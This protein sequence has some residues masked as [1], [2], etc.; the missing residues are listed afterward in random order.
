MEFTNALIN[1]TSPYLLQHAHNPVN[2]LPWSE[3]VFEKAKKENKLVLLSIG[4]SACHWCH[5]MEHESFEDPKVAEIMNTYFINVKIDR[6]ERPDVDMLYMTAVQLMNGQGG[7]PLNC[8]TLPDGR[9]VYGG[10][11]FP[12]QQWVN[13]LHN[14]GELFGNDK[15]KVEQYAQELTQ[16]I[17]QAEL[18]NTKSA[19]GVEL[20]PSVLE[21]C[22]FNWTKR[23]DREYGG[24]NRAPKFPLP[25]NYSFLLKYAYLKNDKGLLDY[26]EL[27]LQKMACGGIYDQLGGGFARYS[28]DIYW[29]VPHFEKML[30]DNAQLVTLYCE[31]YRVSKNPLYKEVVIETLKFVE[32]EFLSPDGGFYSALDADSEGI[33]GKYYVWQEEELKDLLGKHYEVFADYF[34]VN[35]TGYWEDEN[36]ILM[37]TEDIS[38]LLVKHDLKEAELQTIIDESKIILKE[39]RDK[40]IKPGLDDK[41]LTSWNALMCKGYCEAYLTFKDKQYKTI[42][43]RNAEFISEKLIKSD[44]SL[45][46]SYKGGGKIQGFLDDY[47]F[48]IDA[49]LSVYLITQDER[50]IEKADKLCEY[51]FFNFY[52][53]ETGLFYY[54]DLKNEKLVVR[55]TE[56]S[57]NVIPSSNS[58]MAINLFRLSKLTGKENYQKTS[59]EMLRRFS[60][61]IM[62]YGA[63]YSNW[64]SLYI[65]LLEDH[66]EVCIVGKAVEEK[67]LS[68][69][70]YYIPNAI[71]AVAASPSGLELLK[72]RYAE[73]KTLFYI[74]R[75]RTCQLPTSDVKE[76]LIQLE[77]VF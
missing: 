17:K 60:E 63:G 4:Y 50:W 65:D 26:V 70:N 66:Y 69:Y 20:L 11:Y 16:G 31:A 29:K 25:N 52:S 36:Y 23:F 56:T 6:E 41:I 43:L 44:S 51:T 39:T 76:A 58:Q 57:D 40:R 68:L 1:E 19:D 37:R 8:F 45:W 10:A 9:P 2:W 47:A 27:T 62:G 12:K 72:D 42:A 61:E 18:I 49:F 33:E 22:V 46:R 34:N 21:K 67:L 15:A 77:A 74:C 14:L 32:E 13:I 55:T 54:T 38:S 75:N 59:S 71:F 30:Y 73:G 5:V 35:E 28:T 64:A 7:W 48:A 3:G 24:P 53:E